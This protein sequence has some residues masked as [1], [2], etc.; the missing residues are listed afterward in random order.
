[1]ELSQSVGA[2]LGDPKS[3]NI[4]TQQAARDQIERDLRKIKVSLF[5][6]QLEEPPQRKYAKLC[7]LKHH[8]LL[9][10]I[11]KR[12]CKIGRDTQWMTMFG[13]ISLL[14]D[15]GLVSTQSDEHIYVAIFQR[16]Y[17]YHHEHLHSVVTPMYGDRISNSRD[18]NDPWTGVWIPQKK[19]KYLEG[20]QS[21]Y[22][23]AS[24]G[25][26]DSQSFP[27]LNATTKL[28]TAI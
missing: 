25:S 3:Y 18:D 22:S 14:R 15:C 28:S 16:I 5:E 21:P 13:W 1:M 12:Y 24:N 7:V 10:S 8:D 19:K 17:L 4:P 6:Y 9:N 2:I 27:E 11:F 23:A 20:D 26:D